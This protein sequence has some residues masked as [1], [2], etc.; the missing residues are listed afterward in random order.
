LHKEKE[1]PMR[2]M[3]DREKKLWM[4]NVEHWPHLVDE[5]MG[6]K[7]NQ[8]NKIYEFQPNFKK[9]WVNFLNGCL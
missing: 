3:N 1:E 9:L 5:Y 2:E 8:L 6:V 4:E 7:M